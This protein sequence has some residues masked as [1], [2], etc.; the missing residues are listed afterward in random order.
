MDFHFLLRNGISGG[1]FVLF[2][3]LGIWMG[4]PT[5]A[6]SYIE[7]LKGY[8]SLIVALLALTPVIG[9][10]LQGLYLISLY[11][12]GA[13]FSDDARCLVA[14]RVR[15]VIKDADA[16]PSQYDKPLDNYY[17]DPI[18]VA[19]YHSHA[20]SHLIEWARRRRSYHYLGWTLSIAAIAG[21]LGGV[22]WDFL[23]SKESAGALGHNLIS[24]AN[25]LWL[26]V[27]TCGVWA[28]IYLSVRM[29]R[30]VD[31]MEAI[32]ALAYLDPLVGGPLRMSSDKKLDPADA[33]RARAMTQ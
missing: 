4:D 31:Q 7:R 33:S 8:Q 29:L 27:L 11:Q 2:G 30:D 15:K 21:V 23:L 1:M 16:W 18:F 3:C 25:L 9:I 6:C 26:I 17:D 24:A 12:L 32:W 10:C 5:L 19:F 20:P 28:S 22:F 13:M 14:A